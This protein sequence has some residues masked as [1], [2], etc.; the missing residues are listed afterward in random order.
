MAGIAFVEV[1]AVTGSSGLRIQYLGRIKTGDGNE[2]LSK[3]KR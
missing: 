2:G 1:G 3:W